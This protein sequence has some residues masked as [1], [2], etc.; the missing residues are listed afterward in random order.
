MIKYFYF[1]DEI[2]DILKNLDRLSKVRT[3]P[4]SVYGMFTIDG[5]LPLKMLALTTTYT[6]AL[7]QIAFIE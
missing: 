6:V 5:K 3:Q 2:R 7:L 4:F 1:S